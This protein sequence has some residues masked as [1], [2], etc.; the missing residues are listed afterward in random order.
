MPVGKHRQKN[1][2]E[3]VVEAVNAVEQSALKISFVEAPER[4]TVGKN[5]A[6][7]V[8][9]VEYLL[10]AEH[11]DQPSFV[12]H[13]RARKTLEELGAWSQLLRR[14]HELA[15]PGNYRPR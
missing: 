3:N 8:C 11:A 1:G 6:Y 13:I 9:A 5:P 14:R 2:E 4:V 15:S 10:N 12:L 7:P